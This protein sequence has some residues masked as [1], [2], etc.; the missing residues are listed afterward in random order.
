MSRNEAFHGWD[1]L[2]ERIDAEQAKGRKMYEE[3]HGYM[4]VEEMLTRIDDNF[5]PWEKFRQVEAYYNN[6]LGEH[7]AARGV[8]NPVVLH[9]TSNHRG[10]R[11]RYRGEG[12]H[13]DE[14]I[15]DGHHRLA[16]AQFAGLKE[17]PFVRRQWV[18]DTLT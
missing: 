17:V 7:M 8:K 6:P 9:P 5:R 1:Q 15:Y 10:E 16:G 14:Y 11:T 4:P 12:L 18:E 3:P 2:F 13:P